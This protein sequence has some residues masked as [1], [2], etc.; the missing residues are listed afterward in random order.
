MAV[1]CAVGRKV[2]VGVRLGSKTMSRSR[3]ASPAGGHH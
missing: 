3:R 1:M 2:P